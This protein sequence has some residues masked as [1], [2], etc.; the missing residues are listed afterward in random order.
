MPD[1]YSLLLEWRRVEGSSRGL[2]KLPHDFVAATQAYLAD[3]RRVYEG[4]LRQN[5][6]GRK[7]E[8]ARQTFHRASQI[9]RDLI[10][11]RITKIST[12]AF[13]AAVGGNRDLTNALPEERSLFEQLL[14]AMKGHRSAVAPY[15]DVTPPT[16]AAAPPAVTPPVAPSA[17]GAPSR[18]ARPVGAGVVLVRVLKDGRPVEIAGETIELRKEDV[19]SVP[20]ETARILVEGK[21][22][23]RIERSAPPVTT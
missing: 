14:G 19:L 20:P 5:P 13:Q 23:E 4:E 9:A 11:A 15:L 2:G 16:E 22:A 3:T 12:Q 10:D 18:P 7:G 6:S 21:V 1:H 8:V 17:S